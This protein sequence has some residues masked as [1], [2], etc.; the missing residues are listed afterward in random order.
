MQ[1]RRMYL[2]T[3]VSQTTNGSITYARIVFEKWFETFHAYIKY[4][5]QEIK[6]Q[7]IW[8]SIQADIVVEEVKS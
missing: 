5:Q 4:W 6:A 8:D 3:G 7:L 1:W 2:R